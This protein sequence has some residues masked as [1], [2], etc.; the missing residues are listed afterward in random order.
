MTG[1]IQEHL[2]QIVNQSTGIS[3]VC[4]IVSSLEHITGTNW[5]HNIRLC[6]WLVGIMTKDILTVCA[7]CQSSSEACMN[8]WVIP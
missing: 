3:G 1:W 8:V 7:I 6:V 2:G 4:N 5:A